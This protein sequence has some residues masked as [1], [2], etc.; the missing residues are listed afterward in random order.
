VEA[1]WTFSKLVVTPIYEAFS[2]APQSSRGQSFTSLAQ[3][4][5]PH[6]GFL[7]I[8]VGLAI[9][10][11]ITKW[12]VD[13][14]PDPITPP[15]RR[16]KMV[17]SAVDPV[18]AQVNG[19]I[20]WN[21]SDQEVLGWLKERHQIECEAANNIIT[22]AKDARRREVRERALYGLITSGSFFVIT[23]A[24]LQ[25]LATSSFTSVASISLGWFYGLSG[26]A[27]LGFLYRFLTANHAG[28]LDS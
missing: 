4:M 6:V 8:I 18:Q 19:K 1:N 2:R 13:R 3:Q 16:D 25:F 11:L 21:A 27:F 24:L 7:A 5:F 17:P 9:A 14:W 22:I 26:V 28:P 12:I 15:T 23:S 20:H 10:G